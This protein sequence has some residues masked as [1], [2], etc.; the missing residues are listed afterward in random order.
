MP[1]TTARCRDDPARYV[2][3]TGCGNT[4]ALDRPPVLRLALD[5]LRYYADA[6]GV[7]GFR[8]DLAVTLG[9]RANGFDP[10]AP[11][12]QAIAQDPVLRDL[13]LVA[14]PWDLGPG[15]HRVGAFPAPWGEWNDRYRDTARRFWR[16]D[17]G[18]AGEL[19]TRFAGSADLFMARRRA[20]SRSVNFITAH[21]G[22]TLADLVA[23]GHKHNEA[24]GEHNRD[25][26]DANFSWNHGVEGPTG[27]AAINARRARDVRNLL[28]TL[29]TSRGTPMLAMG[30]ELGRTQHGNNNAYAQDTALAWIDWSRADTALA[31][32]VAHL[33]ALRRRHPALRDDRWLTGA[34]ADAS[35]IPDVEWRR[36]DG[37]AMAD[38]DWNDPVRRTLIAVLH[39]AAQ[40]SI[41]ADRVVVAINASEHPVDVR[42]PAAREGQA[43]RCRVDTHSLA[44]PADTTASDVG[45]VTTLAPNSLVVL[46]EVR[47]PA[48]VTTTRR[49][50]AADPELLDRL[51]RAAGIAPEWWDLAGVRHAVSTD[52]KRALL[53]AMGL[54]AATTGDARDRLVALADERDLRVL[55]PLVSAR[56]GHAPQVPLAVANLPPTRRV[57]LHLRREDG[58]ATFLPFI[59]DDLPLD[60]ATAADG[61]A[62]AR[63]VLSL[64][65][66]PAG[67]HTLRLADRADGLCRILVAPPGC[68][69]PPDLAAGARRFGLAAHLYSLRR[70]GDQGIGD[71]TT[72]ELAGAVTAR[73]G[74]SI[75]GINPL[76]ALFAGDRA[77]ASPYH[78]SDRRFLDPIY[79]DVERIPDFADAQRA[80]ALLARHEPALAALR[81][82]ANIDYAAVDAIKREI[83]AA[84]FDRFEQRPRDDALV[85]AVRPVRRSGRHR[86]RALRAVRG[87]RRGAPADALARLARATARTG[88]AGH[89]GVRA[90]PGTVVAL[91]V[92]PAVGG[93]PPARRGGTACARGRVGARLLS[94]PRD[95]RRARRLR[96]VVEP[97][98]VRNGRVDRCAPRSVLARRPGLAP[99]AAESGDDRDVRLRRLPR[100]RRRQHAARR[101]AAHRP[102]DGPRAALLDSGRRPSGGWR[103]RPLS[104]CRVAGRAGAGKRARTVASWSARI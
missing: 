33:I 13:K 104:R 79:I 67:L 87:H 61:R 84:C 42:W 97:G 12:L 21:D 16:G 94:R 7:D 48:A 35:G 66:L 14:E 46:G 82:R 102:R 47:E 89:R 70:R 29:L 56:E 24:N 19:A 11:L 77:R 101:R 64:P 103:V 40:E 1:R 17:G 76:H 6:A 10:D 20:P 4:L 85:V 25:G 53:A 73:A 38:G 72:L 75:V 39:A 28:A 93:G 30:D 92:V 81:K 62:V 26:T 23:Y 49:A 90:T 41:A 43:W 63:R 100:P 15:G 5:S 32:F 57:T 71:F 69:L 86:A 52:A 65:P 96:A 55:P 91:R 37:H 95:R 58:A 50:A 88:R 51:A 27:D 83:L 36:P 80:R 54:S 99:A 44:V 3:D 59:V 45:A 78:P 34:P 2:D 18:L 9:R 74:G 60:F 22:F 31:G 68:H 8:F 98:R